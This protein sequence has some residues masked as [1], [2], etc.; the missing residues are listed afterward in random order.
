[1]KRKYQNII[2]KYIVS[3]VII[4]SLFALI[5]TSQIFA[6]APPVELHLNTIIESV[7]E[8]TILE[9]SPVSITL[10]TVKEVAYT[11][12]GNQEVTMTITSTNV[13][14]TQM[15]MKHT[16]LEGYYI[17]YT[18]KF[19]YGSG[20]KVAVTP[21]VAVNMTGFSSSSGYDI[22]SSMQIIT[23]EDAALAEGEYVDTLTFSI[24]AQ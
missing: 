1:M 9:A 8:F 19:D 24:E 13:T 17:P 7:S 3:K 22:N 4:L 11:L 14:G 12:T 23:V 2:K 5:S 15:R 16:E 18:L 21:G 20:T 6:L 10:G